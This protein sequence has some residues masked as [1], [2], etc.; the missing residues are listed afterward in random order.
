VVYSG[1]QVLV[2]VHQEVVN[3][4]EQQYLVKLQEL[5]VQLELHIKRQELLNQAKL[6]D[7]M[8]LKEKVEQPVR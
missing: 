5:V 3:Q 1:L 7:L 8:E 4:P 6:Q 2:Q